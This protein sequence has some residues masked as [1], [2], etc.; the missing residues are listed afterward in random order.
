[1][2]TASPLAVREFHPEMRNAS[3]C[4]T[5]LGALLLVACGSPTTSGSSSPTPS[6]PTPTPQQSA[7]PVALDPC[8]LVTGSEASSIAGASFS[9]GKE[10]TTSGG[11]KTCVYGAQTVNVFMVLVTQAPDAATAQAD[12]TQAQAQAQAA[13]QQGLP[14]GA[15]VNLNVTNLAV[16]GADKAAIA[17]FNTTI[18]GQAVGLIAIY[19][20]KGPT[21]VTFSDLAVGKTAPTAATMEAQAQ[22][23]LG[24]LP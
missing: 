20:L 10:D 17:S 7:S 2:A 16:A 22:T 5:V 11:A 18:S 9:A 12:W 4:L 1:M 3:R 15:S 8:Q 13:I 24:R 23:T 21:F 14:Q 6:T 19:L